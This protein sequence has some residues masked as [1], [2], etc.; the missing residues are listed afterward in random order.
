MHTL[1]CFTDGC[2][3]S[4]WTMKLL[5]RVGLAILYITLHIYT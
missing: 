4:L 1:D 5:R 2:R 3:I